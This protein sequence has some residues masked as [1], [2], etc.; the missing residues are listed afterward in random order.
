MFRTVPLSII[1][2]FSLYTQQT[3]MTHTI[4]VCTVKNSWCWTEELSDRVFI[5]SVG[6]SPWYVLSVGGVC[7][8]SVVFA[9][10]PWC[11]PS[12]HGVCYQ[13]V[14]FAVSPWCVPSG[15]G[16]CYQSVVF[17]ITPWCV[18]SGRGVCYQSV[19]C[20]IR[21]WFVP[22]AII[23]TYFCL[24]EIIFECEVAMILLQRCKYLGLDDNRST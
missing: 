4:V 19:V 12:G 17:A 10:S 9:I 6:G 24:L 23:I 22:S 2:S 20:A 7:Y 5:F 15:R 21:P 18:P 11:V 14:V 8:Q 13:S 3:C 16:V 1:R